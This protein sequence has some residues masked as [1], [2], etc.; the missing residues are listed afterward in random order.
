MTSILRSFGHLVPIFLAAS[1]LLGAIILVTHL[2]AI[3]AEKKT[4]SR[5]LWQWAVASWVLAVLLV[6]LYP[7]AWG[8]ESERGLSLVPFASMTGIGTEVGFSALFEI[9]ANCVLF[10]LGGFLLQ[11]A[12]IGPRRVVGMCVALALLVEILQ[13]VVA[14]SRVTSVDDVIWAGLGSSAG[15][16]LGRRLRDRRR[17]RV[18]SKA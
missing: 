13:Y 14:V 6:T 12:S 1:L 9:L 7:Q 18:E 8:M 10:V 3:R 5:V 16:F 2:P 11:F 17:R 4:G 15:L